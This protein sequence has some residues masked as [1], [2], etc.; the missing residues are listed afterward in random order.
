M[1]FHFY[2]LPLSLQGPVKGLQGQFPLRLFP[3]QPATLESRGKPEPMQ[4][5]TPEELNQKVCMAGNSFK[6]PLLTQ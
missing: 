5:L 6:A 2:W 3:T 1:Q 4:G